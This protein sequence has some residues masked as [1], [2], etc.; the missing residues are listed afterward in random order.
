MNTEALPPRTVYVGEA[1]GGSVW[2]LSEWRKVASGRAS[3]GALLRI[4][5]A[6][7]ATRPGVALQ[8]P[9]AFSCIATSCEMP[10][11]TQDDF[12]PKMAFVFAAV[13]Q[14]GHL[15]AIDVP[16]NR[17]WLV[18][19]SGVS[20][21]CM[22]FNAVRRREVIV[23]LADNSIHCYNID[24]NQLVAR[25]PAYH[26]SEPMAISV[27][28]TKPIAISN[29]RS[30]SIIWDTEKW[31]RKRLLMGAGPGVQQASFS[32]TGDSIVTAFNDGSI[33]IW[34]SETFNLRWKISLERFAPNPKDGSSI[35]T[36][37]D[38]DFRTK[39]MLIP[40]TSYFSVSANDELMVYGGLSSSIYVWNL[41]EKRLMHEI[42]IPAFKN[43]IIA[44]IQFIGVSN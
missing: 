17:F 3:Q 39:L 30:E 37:E 6:T 28:P 38:A 7:P 42:L 10:L 12:D 24:T 15:F 31:E 20:A 18:A 19:R 1:K 21:V 33:L 27:H 25:L 35:G 22:S 44:Q 8:R 4:F 34:D 13:D 29:S 40:R 2:Q 26:R 36:P 11:S 43:R 14:R 41:T 32:N 23:G 5:N 16:K 9:V